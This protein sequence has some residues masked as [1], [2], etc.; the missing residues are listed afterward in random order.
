MERVP[1]LKSELSEIV[2]KYKGHL[3]ATSACIGGELSSQAL[4]FAKAESSGD[5]ETATIYYNNII[6]FI[7]YC[8]DLFGDDFY[9][10]CAPSTNND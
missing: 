2:N 1:T 4:N 6:N 9:I 7:N 10:E 3:I 5:I 8:V